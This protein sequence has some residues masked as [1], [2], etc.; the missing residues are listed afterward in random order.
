MQPRPRA[1][2]LWIDLAVVYLPEHGSQSRLGFDRLLAR[3]LASARLD[4]T[5]LSQMLPALISRAMWSAWRIAKATM[6]SVGFSAAPVVPAV[7]PLER[8]HHRDLFGLAG[9]LHA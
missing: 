7:A 9:G 5:L 8:A 3:G 2:I 1:A 4:S 6:V